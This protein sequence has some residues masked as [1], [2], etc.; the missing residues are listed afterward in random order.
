MLQKCARCFL[1]AEQQAHHLYLSSEKA[2]DCELLL[3][4]VDHTRLS[5][6][7]SCLGFAACWLSN[8]EQHQQEVVPSKAMSDQENKADKQM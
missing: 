5:V 6:Q 2:P 8:T 1:T 7:I 3:S 4:K